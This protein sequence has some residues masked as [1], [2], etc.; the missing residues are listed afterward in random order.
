MSLFRRR[1]RELVTSD[2]LA[3]YGR[4]EFLGEH[5]GLSPM[6]GFNQLRPLHE[7]VFT[8]TPEDRATVVAELTRLAQTGE[9]ERVGAWKYV[10]DMLSFE[11][12]TQ[13]LVDA[14]LAAVRRMRVTNLSIHLSRYDTDRYREIFGEAPPH[15]GFIG[16]PCFDSA[17]GPSRED[18]HQ[19]AIR[20]AA[21]R[22]VEPVR[23]APGVD[24]GLLPD[25]TERLW[26]FAL[27]VYRGVDRIDPETPPERDVLS[28]VVVAATDVDHD[29]FA[30]LL[31]DQVRDRDPFLG[32]PWPSLGAARFIE[33]YLRPT[34]SDAWRLTAS[35]ALSDLAERGWLGTDVPVGVL[36]SRERELL[37]RLGLA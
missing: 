1:R 13:P 9:W 37:P 30:L 26:T 14:G 15:D 3:E 27:I 36:T 24:P 5:Q 34:A 7:L 31:A 33:E 29:R 35:A 12:D 6:D 21:G 23:A 10:R 22:H 25:L 28:S 18:R 11:A 17:Y 2:Q 4:R 20:A 16:P 8:R 32:G 19:P